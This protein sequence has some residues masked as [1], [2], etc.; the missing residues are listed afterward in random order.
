MA[1]TLANHRC[2]LLAYDDFPISMALLRG[3]TARLR[4]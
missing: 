3:R 1:A 4:P 2:G